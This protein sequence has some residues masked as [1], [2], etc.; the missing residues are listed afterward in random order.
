MKKTIM[1]IICAAA[2]VGAFAQGS[3]QFANVGGGVNA[4]VTQ[5]GTGVGSDFMA[6]LYAGADAGSLAAVGS[7]AAFVGNGYFSGGVV[8]VPGIAPGATGTFQVRAWNSAA[9]ASYS[10]AAANPSGIVGESNVF[11][12]QTGGAGQP[13]G[14]PASLTG[15]QGFEVVPVPEPTTIALGLIGAAA[16]FLRRRK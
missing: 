4:P 15:L 11:T 2:T 13:P 7:P 6:Q 3:V 5:G 1:A 14:P 8:N 16:L 10:A 9:G 12:V